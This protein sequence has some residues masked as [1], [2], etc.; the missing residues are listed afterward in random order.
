[1]TYKEFPPPRAIAD[2]VKAFWIVECTGAT[3]A[4]QVY[5]LLPHSCPRLVFHYHNR[6]SK[7]PGNTDQDQV[8]AAVLKGHTL[9]YQEYAVRGDFGFIGAY[10]YPFTPMLIF[11]VPAPEYLNQVLEIETLAEHSWCASLQERVMEATSTEGRLR[12]LALLLQTRLARR[13]LAV[14]PFEEMI[15]EI[16][17]QKGN[18]PVGELARMSNLSIKQLERKFKSL[19]GLMPKTFCRVVRFQSTLLASQAFRFGRLTSLA[20]DAGYYDQAHFV[21]DFKEL[22]GFPPS[23]Y[24]NGRTKLVADIL[25]QDRAIK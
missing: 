1:M 24:F 25:V 12:I 5:R 4:N 17:A 15:K 22:A 2:F 9:D 8:S 21:N 14:S 3:N 18:I 6:F 7:F 11:G 10:L 13:S 19:I 16:I 23:F 20:L